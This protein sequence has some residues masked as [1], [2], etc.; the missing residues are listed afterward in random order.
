MKNIFDHLNER[1]KNYSSN[2]SEYNNDNF[3]DSD[4]AEISIQF[5]RIQK[6]QLTDLK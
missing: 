6:N 1:D 4:K 3:E 5:L 2:K